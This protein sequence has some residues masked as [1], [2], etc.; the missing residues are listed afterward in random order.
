VRCDP[1]ALIRNAPEGGFATKYI[2]IGEYPMPNQL[3][4][5]ARLHETRV[6]LVENGMVVELHV[7]RRTG[8]EL[9]GNIY[10]GRVVRVLPGMQAAFVDIGIERTA[11]LYVSDVHSGFLDFEK[12]ML[13]N[14][15]GNE[16][17]D[18]MNG[19]GSQPMP[20]EDMSLQIEDLLFEGQ[21]V[22]VQVSKEPFGS[23][24]ARLT[25]H[26]SLPGRH[27]V[28]MPT[29]DHV[30]ISRRIEDVEERERLKDII[31]DIRPGNLDL[32]SGR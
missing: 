22:M 10:R 15:P 1:N 13:A 18:S 19:N 12:M 2:E 26:V 29:V 17:E 21:D 5:N 31:Q 8:Q 9:I 24:G 25:S 16:S 6:A 11:F 28:L 3:I 32:S 20:F 23:K 4:I 14:H 30:G 7:E 27:L